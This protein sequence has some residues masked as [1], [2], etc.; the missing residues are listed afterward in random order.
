MT[1]DV[2]E[3]VSLGIPQR[4]QSFYPLDLLTDHLKQTGIT[5]PLILDHV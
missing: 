3:L 2:F 5:E 4:N 1:L